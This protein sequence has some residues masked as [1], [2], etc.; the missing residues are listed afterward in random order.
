MD[1]VSLLLLFHLSFELMLHRIV[2]AQNTNLDRIATL[3]IAPHSPV[4][5]FLEFLIFIQNLSRATTVDHSGILVRN[6]S[7]YTKSQCPKE[8]P[9][10]DFLILSILFLLPRWFSQVKPMSEDQFQTPQ[11]TNGMMY[12]K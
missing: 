10:M 5:L 7:T 2:V 6:N 9:T 12:P 8:F 11:G 1:V 3:E 4:E